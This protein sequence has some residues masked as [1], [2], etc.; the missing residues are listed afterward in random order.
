MRKL[1]F[2]TGKSDREKQ[3]LRDIVEKLEATGLPP[4]VASSYK[5]AIQGEHIGASEQQ[6]ELLALDLLKQIHNL[7][8]YEHETEISGAQG[9]PDHYFRNQNTAYEVTRLTTNRAN[10]NQSKAIL[11]PFSRNIRSRDTIR[12]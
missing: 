7:R 9:T 5:T 11:I 8:N 2:G 3:D 12:R 10:R 4:D 1:D 6:S